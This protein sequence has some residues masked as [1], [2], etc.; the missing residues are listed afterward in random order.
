MQNTLGCW[1]LWWQRVAAT[2][3]ADRVLYLHYEELCLNTVREITRVLHFLGEDLAVATQGAAQA[4]LDKNP[5][6][7]CKH[8][9]ELVKHWSGLDKPK[10]QK[11]KKKR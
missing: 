3:P 2:L 9:G 4:A 6:L 11:R 1:W 8:K 7:A 5:K 10:K